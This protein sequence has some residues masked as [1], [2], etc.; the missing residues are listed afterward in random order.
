[1]NGAAAGRKGPF[2]RRTL[3]RAQ[4]RQSIRKL[5]AVNAGDRAGFRGIKSARAWQILGGAVV[6]YETMRC[7]G[8]DRA[9]VSP[10][11]LREGIVLE[12]LL[13]L[14]GPDTGLPL[15]PLMFQD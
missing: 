14:C 10:W 5:M 11:A 2:V 9:E 7:L 13:S 1:M 15:Q 6:A 8:I 3:T 12:H 4:L